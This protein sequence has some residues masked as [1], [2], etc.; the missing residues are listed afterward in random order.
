[1]PETPTWTPDDLRALRT[2]GEAARAMPT[3]VADDAM[4]ARLLARAGSGDRTILPAADGG[5]VRRRRDC[6]SSYCD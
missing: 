6:G 4:L 1:M 3:P 2:L 5:P